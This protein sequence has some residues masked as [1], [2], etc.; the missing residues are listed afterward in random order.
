MDVSKLLTILSRYS[1]SSFCL[2]DY[3]RW[4]GQHANTDIKHIDL[5]S[6]LEVEDVVRLEKLEHL[7]SD[8]RQILGLSETQ[9]K[10]SLG[11]ADDLLSPDPEKMHDILAEPVMVISL[12]KKGFDNIRKLPKFIKHQSQRL[13]A[14]DFTA[15]RINK[16]FAIELKTIRMENNPRPEPGV[17]MRNAMIPSWWRVMFRNN[18]ITKIEDKNRR[19]L[20]QLANTKNHLGCHFGMLA[21]Y[22]RRMGPSTLMA[23]QDYLQELNAIRSL[24]PELDYIFFKDY[25]GEVVT[26][27]EYEPGSRLLPGERRAKAARQARVRPLSEALHYDR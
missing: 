22:N 25:F 26:C 15:E 8:A 23:T 1:L 24:Y 6:T 3:I 18:S 27:P 10:T 14:A 20:T 7:L 9:F 21:L 5:I 19:V 13:P 2:S 11:F 12:A 16:K 17:P 4:L